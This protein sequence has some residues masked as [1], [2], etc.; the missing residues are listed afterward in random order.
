MLLEKSIPISYTL[1]KIWRELLVITILSNVIV[2]ID[3]S[4]NVNDY[5]LPLM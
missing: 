3:K 2:F 1:K 4:Y 5:A